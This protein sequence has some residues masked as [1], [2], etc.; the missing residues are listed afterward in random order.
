MES[1]IVQKISLSKL[2]VYYT[3]KRIFLFADEWL[4]YFALYKLFK[5]K[6]Y[7]VWWMVLV[8]GTGCIYTS[9]V[10][11]SKIERQIFDQDQELYALGTIIKRTL[12][13]KN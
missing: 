1:A 11:I 8:Y 3:I 9:Y 4:F 7:I 5:A 10:N 2:I 13:G 6:Y 12:F